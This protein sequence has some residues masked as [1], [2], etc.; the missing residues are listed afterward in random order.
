MNGNLLIL[1]SGDA[2]RGR[3][4]ELAAAISRQGAKVAVADLAC[5]EYDRIL[6]AVERA[7]T[8]VYWP[9]GAGN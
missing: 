8:V 7:D 3:V 9:A 2:E 4:E 5:G 6:D 1:H